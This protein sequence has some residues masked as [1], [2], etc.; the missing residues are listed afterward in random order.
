MLLARGVGVV[1]DKGVRSH[2]K[3]VNG[4]P[5][6][7]TCRRFKSVAVTK[8][9]RGGYFS[10]IAF[11]VPRPSTL[12]QPGSHLSAVFSSVARKKTTTTL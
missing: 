5:S 9:G 12:Q 3:L 8:A 7:E 2:M 11:P 4:I 6:I 10:T 1:D